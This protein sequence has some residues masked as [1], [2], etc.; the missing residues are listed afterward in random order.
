MKRRT[1]RG[2]SLPELLIVSA[3]FSGFLVVSY[4]LLHSGL[5]VW[6]K[7]AGSQ[8]VDMEL[9][10]ARD[11]LRRDLLQ[12]SFVQCRVSHYPTLAGAD[13]TGDVLWM[14]SAEDPTTGE[15]ARDSEGTPFWQR[16]VV[17]YCVVPTDHDKYYGTA[18]GASKPAD[19]PHKLLVRRVIDDGTPTRPGSRAKNEEALLDTVTLGG[20]FVVPTDRRSIPGGDSNTQVVAGG[21]LD[22]KV[23]L[24]PE[25][26]WPEEVRVQLVGLPEKVDGKRL[27][28]GKGDPHAS[29]YAHSLLFSVQ[30]GNTT[31]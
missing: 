15:L 24:A 5:G 29:S 2:F 14:L 13:N 20:L 30:P 3:I 9:L 16:N 6:T 7:T 10:K 17:Y 21:V 12:A 27:E 18:C 25:A 26:E 28:L 11:T 4:L 31:Q 23:S 22:F 8:D 19:C 1:G